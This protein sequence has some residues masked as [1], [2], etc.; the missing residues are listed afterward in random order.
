MKLH[1]I[2]A[3]YNRREVT[4]ACL[5]DLIGS[6][7]GAHA[8][9]RIVVYDDGSAD[10]S[11][12]AVREI[13]NDITI[14][15]GDG[16][17]FW[18]SGMA[19]AE[20][21]VLADTAVADDDLVVWLNDDVRL[22]R[23]AVARLIGCVE[24]AP[25]GVLVG[26]V[27]EPGTTTA[28]YSGF[29]RRG[30]HPLRFD[31]VQPGNGTIPVDT[32]NGNLVLVPVSVAREMGGID[33]VYAHALADIDYGLRARRRGIHV[34]LAPGTFGECARN[35]ASSGSRIEQWRRFRSV[36]GGGHYQS[37]KRFIKRH[38]PK[39]WPWALLTSYAAWWARAILPIGRH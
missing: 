5:R 25:D 11:A 9:L 37:T 17:A 14:I 10:G 30:W 35:A 26:A 15:E 27:R 24:A 34:N 16:S 22:D 6:A 31:L 32:F 29:R 28:S 1:V 8:E 12:A 39:A 7:T 21:I 36:K 4:V 38:A 13:D 20:A 23:D 33:G 19:S 3:I 2:L 18:A